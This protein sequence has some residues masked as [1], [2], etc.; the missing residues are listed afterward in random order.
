MYLALK[1]LS[2]E[3]SACGVNLEN[4]V[5][6]RDKLTLLSERGYVGELSVVIG[7]PNS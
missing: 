2:L 3:V 5:R 1:A 6:K 7:W 4:D